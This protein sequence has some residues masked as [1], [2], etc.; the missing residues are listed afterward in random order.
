MQ[1]G[2]FRFTPANGTYFQ[3]MDYSDIQPDMDDLTFARWLT[4]QIGVAATPISVFYESPPEQR[5]VR[6]C[7]AKSDETLRE[8]AEKLCRI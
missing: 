2:R 5:L 3:L 8:A 1:S 7:F 6:F 4:T